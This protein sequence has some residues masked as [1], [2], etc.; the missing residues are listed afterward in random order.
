MKK[1]KVSPADLRDLAEIY[2]SESTFYRKKSKKHLECDT[3]HDRFLAQVMADSES[4]FIGIEEL[5]AVPLRF[6]MSQTQRYQYGRS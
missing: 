4:V 6:S 1:G 3:K 5:Y 2:H